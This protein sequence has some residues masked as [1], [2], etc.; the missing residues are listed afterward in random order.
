MI[1]RYGLVCRPIRDLL[2]DYLKE[3]QPALDYTSL[4]SLANFLGGL[5]WADLERHH[6]GIDSLHLPPEVAEAWKQRL[7]T[8]PK[9][10]RAPD[11]RTTETQVP[12]INYRECLTPVRA[13]YLDLAHWAV[14]D[15]ARWA[16]WVAPCPVG[17][18]EIN[19]R[20]DKRQRKSRMD[21]R[22]RE[23]A[24]SAADAAPHRRPGASQRRG[25]GARYRSSNTQDRATSDPADRTHGA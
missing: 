4:N 21:A 19:R 24:A 13:F 6:P 10:I 22:T 18:E 23:R 7:R 15:P 2:V 11:G 20:K 5:F 8:V 1:D 9:T 12:R 17:S 3:R 14:E 25:R 16:A